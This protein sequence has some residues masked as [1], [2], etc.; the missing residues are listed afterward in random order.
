MCAVADGR[1]EAARSH[2]DRIALGALH[3]VQT[4]LFP[5]RVPADSFHFGFTR[6]HR[7]MNSIIWLV[8]L[9]VIV[10]AA[11]SFFGLR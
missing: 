1:A 4:A 8:G 10:I 11:L 7:I 2:C 6:R 9:V 3:G 5:C